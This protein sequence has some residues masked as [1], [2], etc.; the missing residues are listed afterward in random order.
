MINHLGQAAE[1]EA[2]NQWVADEYLLDWLGDFVQANTSVTADIWERGKGQVQDT[3]EFLVSDTPDVPAQVVLDDREG[4]SGVLGF[5]ASH[6]A[7]QNQNLEAPAILEGIAQTLETDSRYDVDKWATASPQILDVVDFF[8]AEI[9]AQDK[10]LGGGSNLGI[11]DPTLA[12]GELSQISTLDLLAF[13]VIGYDIRQDPVEKLNYSEKFDTSVEDVATVLGLSSSQLESLF[14]ADIAIASQRERQLIEQIDPDNLFERRR[15]RR[16]VT[17]KASF[18]QEL[19]AN[20]FNPGDADQITQGE[21]NHSSNLPILGHEKGISF[22]IPTSTPVETKNSND[23]LLRNSDNDLRMIYGTALDD[24]LEGNHTKNKLYGR[25]GHDHLVGG[26]DHDKLLG[27]AGHDTLIGT[28][29]EA[30]GV[31]EK[32]VLFGG[33]GDDIFVLGGSTGSILC[34]SWLPRPGNRQ[35]FWSRTR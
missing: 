2:V 3:L 17:S 13:D 16:R 26:L 7:T 24:R 35:R 5:Q 34:S 14:V 28:D 18:W 4:N 23:T 8:T 31:G 20:Y 6:W 10:T 22:P 12:P 30:K 33:Q 32:D 15:R 21:A 19:D 27:Q 29:G 11:L 1:N 25:R 9:S